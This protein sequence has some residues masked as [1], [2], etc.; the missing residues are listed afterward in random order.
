MTLRFTVVKW[1]SHTVASPCNIWPHFRNLFRQW[2]TRQS[3]VC[4]SVFFVFV[5]FLMSSDVIWHHYVTRSHEMSLN[6]KFGNL[7]YLHVSNLQ[8][9]LVILIIKS[10]FCS[11]KLWTWRVFEDC[12]CGG[13]HFEKISFK[14]LT[15]R[16]VV[17]PLI[18]SNRR[19]KC[20]N[21]YQF[22]HRNR[23]SIGAPKE[24]WNFNIS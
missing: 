15:L 4:R 23:S 5:W 3:T 6:L 20:T 1:N 9:L 7:R 12:L 24:T 8:V 14:I 10:R 2:L 18:L 21:L 13:A 16:W 22:W 11:K 17:F 19:L